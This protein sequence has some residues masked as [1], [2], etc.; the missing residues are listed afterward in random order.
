MGPD[1]ICVGL[2]KAGTRWL[3]DQL[4]QTGGAWMP[5]IKEIN[6]FHKKSF[7]PGNMEELK[8]LRKRFLNFKSLH[9]SLD[10]KFYSAFEK[11]LIPGNYTDDWYFSLFADKG[12][13]ISGDISPNYSSLN[14]AQVSRIS[15]Q[16]PNASVLLLLRHPVDRVKS[17]MSMKVRDGSILEEDI[18]S[19]DR[20]RSFVSR[21]GVA[22]LSYPTQIWQRWLEY[23]GSERCKFFFME[24]IKCNP[25]MVRSQVSDFIGLESPKFRLPANFNRKSKEK[26]Y[27]FSNE[28]EFYLYEFFHDEIIKCQEMF[29]GHAL[30]WKSNF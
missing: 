16:L 26:K 18:N 1:F 2:Q 20:V 23:F 11:G 6:Y 27:R 8:S 30:N 15:E 14:D 17:A 7:K 29:K 12:T 25:E 10:R 19:I 13:Y 22:R 9:R 4:R 24:D 3:H 21:K 28:I 5:P